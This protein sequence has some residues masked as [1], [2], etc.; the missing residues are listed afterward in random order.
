[1]LFNN[2]CIKSG[3]AFV[4]RGGSVGGAAAGVSSVWRHSRL[5]TSPTVLLAGVSPGSRGGCVGGVAAFSLVDISL[6]M[7]AV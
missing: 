7:A 6:G 1:M 2:G 4:S 3:V 5:A